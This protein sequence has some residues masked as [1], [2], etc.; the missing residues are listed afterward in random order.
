MIL[1][2]I[3]MQVVVF[4]ADNRDEELQSGDI[5]LKLGLDGWKRNKLVCVL[6]PL[7]ESGWLDVR[8]SARGNTYRAGRRLA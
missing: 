4:F 1:A 5:A 2:N 6:Q 8:R 3:R 7:V